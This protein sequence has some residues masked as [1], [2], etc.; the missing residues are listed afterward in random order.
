[1]KTTILYRYLKHRLFIRTQTNGLIFQNAN[2][3]ILA[4]HLEALGG[5]AS[6]W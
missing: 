6:A 5:L 4:M 2:N 1:M 3:I